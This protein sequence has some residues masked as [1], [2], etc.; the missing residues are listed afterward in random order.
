MRNIESY[1][2]NVFLNSRR[3]ESNPRNERIINRTFYEKNK[4][5]EL[6]EPE[7]KRFKMFMFPAESAEGRK[8][9]GFTPKTK[10]T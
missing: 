1:E 4:I 3:R 6:T 10:K 5:S 9:L 2:K 8:S 7:V